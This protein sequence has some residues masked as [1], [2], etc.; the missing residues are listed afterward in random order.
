[1]EQLAEGIFVE[2][3]YE[4]VNV[5]TIVTETG[6]VAIDAPTYPR[7][8]RD[9]AMR[10]HRLTPH[11][12]I[13]LILTDSHGDRILNTRWLNAPVIAHQATAQRLNS[14]DKRYPLALLESLL[15]RNPACAR[16]LNHNPVERPTLSF[17][18]DLRIYQGGV[19]IVALAAPGPTAGNVWL[20]LPGSGV[21]FTGDTVVVDTHPSL[22]EADSGQW[23]AT[24]E[25]LAQ[26]S[27]VT[28]LVPGR[29]PVSDKSAVAPVAGYIRQMRDRLSEHVAENRPSGQTAALIPEFVNLFPTGDLPLKWVEQQVKLGLDRVYNEVK[30]AQDGAV[31]SV[32]AVAASVPG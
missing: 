16:D 10:L 21:L 23:L 28:T 30:L 24:L 2:T 17:S 7:D 1:M 18:H 31:L 3:G 11:P 13:N 20:F 27:A 6:I 12:V 29:G 8:A 26:W 4:G 15:A 9:W 22:A 19:E 5:G 32:K 25:R 14:Y